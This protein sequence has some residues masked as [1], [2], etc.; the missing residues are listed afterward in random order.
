MKILVAEDQAPSALFIRRMLERLGHDVSIAIDGE[1]AWRMAREERFPVIISDWMMP[2]LDGPELCRRIRAREGQP[3]TY[4][5]LLTC[6]HSQDDRLVG[7][8][9]GADD[10]LVKPPDTEELKIRLE[11]ARR[12]LAVQ[13]ELERRNRLLSELALSDEL[14]GVSNR[15]RFRQS[16]DVHHSQ[17]I[18][19]GVPLS[20]AMLDVDFFKGYND[21][22]GHPAGDEVLRIV[23]RTLVENV[24]KGDEVARIGGEEFAVILPDTDARVALEL[25][26]RLRSTLA[27]LEWPLRPVTACVGVA[28]I[29]DSSSASA[30]DP[31]M[32][33]EHAD[34]ALYHCKRT[35]R[36]R[37]GHFDEVPETAETL[38]G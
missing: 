8:R 38:I 31:T 34:R 9:A 3:Y 35:G 18:R 1:H 2:G 14:T 13:D 30:M 22:F 32:F 36:D 24:R 15:R 29:A 5:I 21:T 12:I 20:L 37:A 33:I 28:T 23:A 16:L 26:E 10:F 17:A 6:K 11:I 27:G 25:A 19:Q 4:L 7:L